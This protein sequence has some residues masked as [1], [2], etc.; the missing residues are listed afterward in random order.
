M[1][2]IFSREPRTGAQSRTQ[3]ISR[4]VRPLLCSSKLCALV[5]CGQFPAMFCVSCALESAL[6]F[7]CIPRPTFSCSCSSQYCVFYFTLDCL[8]LHLRFLSSCTTV[9]AILTVLFA[10]SMHLPRQCPLILSNTKHTKVLCLLA[11]FL[12][13]FCVSSFIHGDTF[14]FFSFHRI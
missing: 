8:P 9:R 13:V 2:G 5:L 6:P 10:R 7:Q 1:R 11:A 12:M 4:L 3:P 14:R